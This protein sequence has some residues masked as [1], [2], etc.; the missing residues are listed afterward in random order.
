M[1]SLYLL[2]TGNTTAETDIGECSYIL[3]DLSCFCAVR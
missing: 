2:F 1:G 3:S